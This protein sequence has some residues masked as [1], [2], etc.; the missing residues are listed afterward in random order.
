[1]RLNPLNY[2]VDRDEEDDEEEDEEDD[3]EDD[4]EEDKEDDEDIEYIPD[5]QAEHTNLSIPLD[6]HDADSDIISELIFKLS[7]LL[8]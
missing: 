5:D 7:I 1:L 6:N 3:D 2:E 4:D 8:Y